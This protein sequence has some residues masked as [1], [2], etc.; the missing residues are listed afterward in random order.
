MYKWKY[1][2]NIFT[3][4]AKMCI[5]KYCVNKKYVTYLHIYMHNKKALKKYFTDTYYVFFQDT[6]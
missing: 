1:K 6:F 4:F 2:E 3:V 5:N